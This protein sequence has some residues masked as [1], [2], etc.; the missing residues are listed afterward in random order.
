MRH[1]PFLL[2]A[3]S[4]LTGLSFGHGG[5]YPP[6]PPAPSGHVPEVA[7]PIGGSPAGPGVPGR[8]STPAP[9][10]SAPTAS[11]PTPGGKAAG[12]AT[13][14]FD[15]AKDLTAWHY[16]WHFNKDPYLRLKERLYS[17]GPPTTGSEE[18]LGFGA[19][20]TALLDLR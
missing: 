14:G 4:L 9:S 8:A 5:T 7:R 15:P 3:L 2:A 12:P 20:Q 6:L 13:P 19:S 11:T 10:P 17:A 18:F 16:W 1:F